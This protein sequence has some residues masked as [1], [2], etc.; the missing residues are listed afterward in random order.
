MERFI[1]Q[2]ADRK[3]AEKAMA[4]IDEAKE[5]LKSQGIDQWQTG[6]PDMETII[7]DLAHGR[8]YFIGEG[9][10]AAA[11][12]CIDFAGEA[13]Y[14]TL[15]GSWKSDLPYAVVHRMAISGAY[16]GHGIASIAFQLIEE[17]C[18]QKGIYSVR[19]DTDEKNAI[20]RH[21]LEKNGF[22]YCGTIWFDN[23]VKYAYEKCLRGMPA[24]MEQFNL[25]WLSSPPSQVQTELKDRQ[26]PDV[27]T[28]LSFSSVFGQLMLLHQTSGKVTKIHRIT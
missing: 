6:Y 27:C 26:V 24:S 15:Q 8:G 25:H 2:P 16:R 11:Y 23:S 17:L 9:S 10:S 20:M 28:C 18:I 14:E 19:V 22:D 12:L 5:F 13:S 4:L 21:V 3:E 1:L 7:G